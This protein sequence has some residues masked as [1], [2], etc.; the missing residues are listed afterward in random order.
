MS[1]LIFYHGI[2]LP[3]NDPIEEKDPV[4]LVQS[5]TDVDLFNTDAAKLNKWT[6]LGRLFRGE[7]RKP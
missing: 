7:Y 5:D 4:Y 1:E 6:V 2:E 3:F